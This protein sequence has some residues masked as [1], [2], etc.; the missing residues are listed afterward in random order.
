MTLCVIILFCVNL[1]VD[2][3]IQETPVPRKNY[4]KQV[5]IN[6]IIG[7]GFGIGAG[8]FYAKSNDVYEDYKK[9]TIMVD[10]LDNWDKVR[11]YDGVRNV[12]AAGAL[13]FIFRAVYYQLK[14][15]KSS[16]STSFVP[17]MDFQLTNNGKLILG[18]QKNL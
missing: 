1:S 3:L 11:L 8:V 13:I 2:S 9:S 14:N 12:C 15:V 17:V 5:L 16:K 18:I 6:G 4:T 7:I 10:A